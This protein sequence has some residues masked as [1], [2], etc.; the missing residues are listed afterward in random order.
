MLRVNRAPIYYDSYED[1]D[2]GLT[3][4]Q[5]KP[6][7]N[8]DIL[9][10]PSIISTECTVAIQHKDGETLTHGTKL[11]HGDANHNSQ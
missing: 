6:T 5:T 8:I 3:M 9:K 11:E 7:K 1:F 2:K 4:C 10:E